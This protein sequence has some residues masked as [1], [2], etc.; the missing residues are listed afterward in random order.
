MPDAGQAWHNERT[1]SAPA[2][3]RPTIEFTIT[4]TARNYV[5]VTAADLAVLEDGVPQAVDTETSEPG[6]GRDG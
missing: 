1:R 6:V 2:P 3:I 4:D 5:D